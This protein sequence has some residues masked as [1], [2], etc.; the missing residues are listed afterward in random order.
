[1]VVIILEALVELLKYMENPNNIVFFAGYSDSMK[2]VLNLNS[3]LK[4]R[5]STFINF[6]DYNIEELI[7]ILI[8]KLR[9]Q[10]F[11]IEND[12]L[13]KVK[14]I[15]NKIINEKNFGNGRYIDK[16]ITKILIKHAENVELNI[17][18][19][20]LQISKEDINENEILNDKIKNKNTFGFIYGN[21]D[22]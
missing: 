9:R 17:S 8:L 22:V 11:S 4:S 6:E 5:V 18:K 15:L 13:D 19:D 3:G 14:S 21:G 2:N 1:M 16:L 7:Q 12:A 20:L 10:N